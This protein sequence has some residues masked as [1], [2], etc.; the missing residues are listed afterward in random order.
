MSAPA[1]VTERG[2]A[3]AGGGYFRPTR[4][5]KRSNFEL[6]SW[7]FMRISGL[8]LIFL[9]LYHLVWWNLVIGVEHL[10]SQVVIER[11]RNP[12][13]RLFNVAL[14]VFAMLHG[15][16]GARYSIEDYVRRPGLQVAVKSVV[17]TLVL[18]ALAVAVFALLTFD[19]ATLVDR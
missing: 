10:D 13:W 8:L 2:A 3:R 19:P 16:N 11:W 9:A 17:Y 5:G 15:L 12:F 4:T 1:Q 7:F 18:G 14:V 6:L